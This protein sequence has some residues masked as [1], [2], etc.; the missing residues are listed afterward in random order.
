MVCSSTYTIAVNW[1]KPRPGWF[2]CNIGA[3]FHKEINKTS[4]GWCLRD[5]MGRFVSSDTTWM[6]GSC[7]ILEGESIALL[8]A[9][10]TLTHRGI[11][12]VIFETDSK[13]VVDSID[14][15][16]GGSSEFSSLICRI[17][18]IL[19][20]NQNFMVKFIR[21][22]A[23]NVAHTLAKAVLSWSRRCAS[24]LKSVSESEANDFHRVENVPDSTV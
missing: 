13:S 14:H 17:N 1:Q 24:M 6:D 7:T 2:K 21:R 4:T 12:H 15:L 3:G 23:N 9:L 22:Q 10:K 20:C 11:S 5:H 16:Y 8:E 19:L 18:N